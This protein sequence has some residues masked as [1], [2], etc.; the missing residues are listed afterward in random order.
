M[1]SQHQ[2]LYRLIEAVYRA[3]MRDEGLQLAGREHLDVEAFVAGDE[4]ARAALEA[5]ASE[6]AHPWRAL[7]TE[8]PFF[9]EMIEV[10][11]QDSS[12]PEL[13]Q[14]CDDAGDWVM[15]RPWSAAGG[16]IALRLRKGHWRYYREPVRP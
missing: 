9:G 5:L 12:Y 7:E 1:A 13:Y 8:D 2:A 11:E 16:P 6:Q 3:S 10:W 4:E 15:A 14:V